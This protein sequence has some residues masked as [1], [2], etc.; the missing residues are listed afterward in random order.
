[1]QNC[2][3]QEIEDLLSNAGLTG[4]NSSSGGI[5]PSREKSSWK[6]NIALLSSEDQDKLI[7]LLIEQITKRDAD[8]KIA[9]ADRQ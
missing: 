5:I 2:F 1:M 7:H 9:K 6:D 8:H 3:S 4:G